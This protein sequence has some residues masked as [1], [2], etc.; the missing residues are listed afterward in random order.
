MSLG[1]S[2]EGG[3]GGSMPPSSLGG[4]ESQRGEKGERDIEPGLKV[5]AWDSEDSSL[6]ASS[7]PN[8]LFV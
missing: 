7:L 2:S 3:P 6:R 1:P 4:S 8:A 5:D